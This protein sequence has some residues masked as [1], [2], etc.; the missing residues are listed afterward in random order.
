MSAPRSSYEQFK[1]IAG[2][3][4]NGTMTAGANVLAAVKKPI[5]PGAQAYHMHAA[6][7]ILFTSASAYELFFGSWAKL[8]AD[9]A[10]SAYCAVG[11]INQVGKAEAINL[12]TSAPRRFIGLF[13]KSAAKNEE[14]AS[15]QP[16]AEADV[17][18]KMQ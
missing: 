5:E 4:L 15:S 18:P 1:N 6:G 16:N 9:M 2:P 10:I 11:L 12:A 17:K 8:G 7:L 14:P 3:A 13:S